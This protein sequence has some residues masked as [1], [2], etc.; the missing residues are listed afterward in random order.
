MYITFFRVTNMKDNQLKVEVSK[1]IV[2]IRSS[3]QPNL[4][5]SGC[6][7][8][9]S[10]IHCISS[11]DNVQ[12]VLKVSKFTALPFPCKKQ[13]LMNE[14]LFILQKGEILLVFKSWIW[15]SN[16]VKSCGTISAWKKVFTISDGCLSC[17]RPQLCPVFHLKSLELLLF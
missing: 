12:N 9:I 2:V 6:A 1:E 11:G 17:H 5:L 14:L 4:V 13:F 15:K 3:V 16:K 7:E 8:S 10:L